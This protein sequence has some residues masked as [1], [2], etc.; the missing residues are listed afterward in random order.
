[1]TTVR[2]AAVQASYELMDREATIDRVADLTAAAAAQGAELVVFPEAFIPGTPFWIDTQP[3]WE[4]DADWFRMLAENAVAVPGPAT[5][6]LGTIA[7]EN[8]VWL[9]IGVQEREPTG[10]TIYNTLLYVSPEGAVV[11]KHRKLVPTG[12]ERTVWGQGDG[13]TLRVVSTPFG[14]IGGLICWENYMPLARFHLYAQGVDLWVAPTLAP[15]DAWVASMRHLARENRMF[16]VGVN[17]VLHSDRI[18]PD[19]P[20]RDKLIPADF[21]DQN[22]GW[23]EQ[24][25][26]VIVGPDGSLI[27]G[28]VRRSE[29]TL[30]AELDLGSVGAARRLLDPVGHYNRPDVFR[31]HVDTSPRPPVVVG[32]FERSERELTYR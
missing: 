4:G 7:R 5:E 11:E 10:G 28:P 20:D 30:I 26:S 8:G 6:R 23:V 12:S 14:R 15:G 24:G 18:R 31:L 17:P 1:M 3:I 27:A 21:L 29:E 16:V 22:D 25:N 9:A 32:S 2:V 13:S 19:F